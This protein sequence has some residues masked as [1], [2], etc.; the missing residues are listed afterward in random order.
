[1]ADTHEKLRCPACQKEMEKVFIKKEGVN[2]DICTD[3][4]GGMWFDN[5]ELSYLDEQSENIDEI[6][7]AITNKTFESVD[8]SNHRSCPACGAR[9]VKNFSSAKKQIQID[10]CYACGGKFLDNQELLKFRGEY[11][12][13]EERSQDVVKMMYSTVGIELKELAKQREELANSRSLA[14]KLFDKMIYD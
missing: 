9:M 1:M 2:I 6:L 14:K 3:G 5:R 7:T 12:T 10:E 11:N 4:C 13:E 8:E